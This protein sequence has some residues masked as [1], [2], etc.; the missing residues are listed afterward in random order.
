MT[1]IGKKAWLSLL[2]ISFTC[3]LLPLA[4][5]GTEQAV[6][7]IKAVVVTMFE[8]GE[9]EGDRPGEFQFWVERFPLDQQLPFEMGQHPLRLSASGVLGICTGAGRHQCHSINHGLGFGPEV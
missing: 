3:A 5:A 6:I 8:H 4:K 9:S 1:A 2:V 7:P